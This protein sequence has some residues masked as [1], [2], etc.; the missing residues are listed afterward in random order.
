MGIAV[1]S[2]VTDS[3]S[4]DKS[5]SLLGS[6]KWESH[7][8]GTMTPV[9]K[10]DVST[11]SKF[12]ACVNRES[13]AKKLRST[14]DALGPSGQQIHVAAA[15]NVASVQQSDVVMLW[16]VLSAFVIRVH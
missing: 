8:P 16:C 9:E 1:L 13:T 11:P 5:R 7:T 2:G 14:F 6:Q 12:I 10:H 3:L 4:V 15:Q